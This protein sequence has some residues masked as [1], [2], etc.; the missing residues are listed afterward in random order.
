MFKKWM[1]KAKHSN[2]CEISQ[3]EDIKFFSTSVEA[4]VLFIKNSLVHTEDLMIQDLS[5]Q[6][7]LL[8]IE[9]LVDVE[10]ISDKVLTR[11]TNTND[12]IICDKKIVNL[13]EATGL[14]LDGYC[15]FMSEGKNYAAVFYTSALEKR[16]IQEPLSEKVLRGPHDGFIES[17]ETNIQLVRRSV[18][19]PRLM[20]K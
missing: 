6:G 2:E 17:L 5:E 7:Y 15:I 10:K 1:T 4:D 18:K 13:Y 11:I 19:N 20:I 8:F 16:S 12:E 9:S 3:N 14:L